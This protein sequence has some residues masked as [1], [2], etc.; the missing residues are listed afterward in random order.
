[1][2]SIRDRLRAVRQRVRRAV[3]ARRRLLAAL[4]TAAAVASGL[5]AVTAPPPT[6]TAVLTASRD[7]PAGTVLDADDLE[8]TGFAPD[9][10]PFGAS[11][12]PL[13]HTLAAPLRRGEPVTDVRLVGAALTAGDADL[14]ALPIRIPDAGAV[15]LLTVGDR[16]D[17][18]AT[19][20]QGS[21]AQVVAVDV[22]VLALPAAA[23]SGDAAA[24]PGGL[25]VVGAAP[26]E[27][28]RLS[29]AAVRLFLTYAFS[30]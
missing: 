25:V 12:D 3:L 14:V 7:L 24:Q 26:S 2:S 18:I 15:D 6:T 8:P 11:E 30:R 20:P 19:D 17:L 29:D 28:T 10:V 5:H 9:S 27:V 21:G 16:I 13:G 23:G 1:M 22:P 4:F